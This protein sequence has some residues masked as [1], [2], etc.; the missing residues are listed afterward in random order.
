MGQR[1]LLPQDHRSPQRIRQLRRARNH[2]HRSSDPC[3]RTPMS[4]KSTTRP[5]NRTIVLPYLILISMATFVLHRT[6][7]VVRYL[8][9]NQAVTTTGTHPITATESAVPVQKKKKN[10]LRT[11][12]G[13]Y[14]KNHRNLNPHL[15]CP[16]QHGQPNRRNRT[17]RHSQRQS[18]RPILRRQQQQTIMIDI[19]STGSKTKL[20]FVTTQQYASFGTHSSVRYFMPVTEDHDT[21]R[22]CAQQLSISQYEAVLQFCQQKSPSKQDPPMTS[23]WSSFLFPFFVSSTNNFD[24]AGKLRQLLFRPKRGDNHERNIGWLCAQQRPVDGLRIILDQYRQLVRPQPR[25]PHM[26]HPQNGSGHNDTATT[27][28]ESINDVLPDYLIFMDD[29]TYI[30][31]DN[32]LDTLVEGYPAHE[33]QVL[34]GCVYHKP[35]PFLAFPWGGYGTI[36][37]RAALQRFFQPI[38]CPNTTTGSATFHDDSSNNSDGTFAEYVCWRIHQHNYINESL[39]FRNGMSVADLMITFMQQYSFSKINEWNNRTFGYCFHSDHTLGYFLNFYFITTR[40]LP[41]FPLSSSDDP[42]TVTANTFHFMERLRQ[43]SPITSIDPCNAECG[44]T[45]YHLCRS[46]PQRDRRQQPRICHKIQP[47]DMRRLYTE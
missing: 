11:G 46:N 21:D 22:A 30:H 36:L 40:D 32:L 6:V 37:S 3:F 27:A 45:G 47:E 29:D 43:N 20:D 17:D 28:H 39:F 10:P 5:T 2:H 34:S 13:D 7:A 4:I 9:V 16:P 8:Y 44:R 24:S 35:R 23:S 31:M 19:V 25:P 18:D 42:A 38:H 12:F 15:W 14:I 41:P 33:I 1:E 26:N